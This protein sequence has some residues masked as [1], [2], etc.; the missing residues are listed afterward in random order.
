MNC[1]CVGHRV[2]NKVREK[3]LQNKKRFQ[4]NQSVKTQ[5][6]GIK[7]HHKEYIFPLNTMH[8]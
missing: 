5:R 4:Q 3:L 6:N 1:E 2:D 7:K 8:Y